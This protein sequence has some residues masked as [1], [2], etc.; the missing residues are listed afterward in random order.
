MNINDNYL[1]MFTISQLY[2]IDIDKYKYSILVLFIENI[3]K[4]WGTGLLYL[5]LKMKFIF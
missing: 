1:G 2:D 4:N 5:R 3:S